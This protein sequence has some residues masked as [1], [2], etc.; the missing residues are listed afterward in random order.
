MSHTHWVHDSELRV[1]EGVTLTV[2]MAVNSGSMRGSHTHRVH[3]SEL[4][5]HEGVTH[6]LG[7]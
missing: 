1:H 5:V 4:R 2:S 6:S 7:P 3:G